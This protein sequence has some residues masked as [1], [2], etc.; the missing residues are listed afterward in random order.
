MGHREQA[1]IDG[2]LGFL[3]LA[4]AATTSSQ[5]ISHEFPAL[6]SAQ[7]RWQCAWSWQNELEEHISYIGVFRTHVELIGVFEGLRS[8]GK[9]LLFN[10]TDHS[11]AQNDQAA[12][13]FVFSDMG[14]TDV[15]GKTRRWATIYLLEKKTGHF[16]KTNVGV[17]DAPR[18]AIGKC[19]RY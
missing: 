13:V 15:E 3:T 5:T 2:K 9:D 1:M 10:E 19:R 11:V 17:G 6:L 8:D 14:N 7:E 16:Q 18:E 12:L 4:I